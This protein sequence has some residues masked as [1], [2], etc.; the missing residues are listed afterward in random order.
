MY[1]LAGMKI[2]LCP[3][4]PVISTYRDKYVYFSSVTILEKAQEYC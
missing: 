4:I 1:S 2:T 3:M